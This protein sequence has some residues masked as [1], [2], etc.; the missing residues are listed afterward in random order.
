MIDQNIINLWLSNDK[1][2]RKL[3]LL[4]GKSQGYTKNQVRREGFK[5]V[6]ANIRKVMVDYLPIAYEETVELFKSNKWTHSIKMYDIAGRYKYIFSTRMQKLE[7]HGNSYWNESYILTANSI[8]HHNNGGLIASI[9]NH[10]VDY[11]KGFD[12][13]F[14]RIKIQLLTYKQIQNEIDKHNH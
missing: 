6:K 13:Q 5:I 11:R 3:A 14:Y 2:N 1:D 12:D 9:Q 4:L 7:L 8:K 10:L